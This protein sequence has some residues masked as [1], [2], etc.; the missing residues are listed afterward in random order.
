[1]G[2]WYRGAWFAGVKEIGGEGWAC[3]FCCHWMGCDG[4]HGESCMLPY[5]AEYLCLLLLD[6]KY[7]WLR[8][9]SVRSASFVN[10]M[11]FFKLNG[12]WMVL[13]Y[14]MQ[15]VRGMV[16]Q[17]TM[18]VDGPPGPMKIWCTSHKDEGQPHEYYVGWCGMRVCRYLACGMGV[19]FDCGGTVEGVGFPCMQVPLGTNKGWLRTFARR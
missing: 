16:T 10:D 6:S 19:S 11:E 15:K 17:T 14:S 4:R 2:R 9:A 8:I 3:C 13:L 7:A 12:A 5:G 18:H 1:M